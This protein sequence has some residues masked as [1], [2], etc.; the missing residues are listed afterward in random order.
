MD[1]GP[2]ICVMCAWRENCRLKY[3]MDGTTTTRCIHY[4]RDLALKAP[5]KD[6]E[7]PS[8]KDGS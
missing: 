8:E 7:E 5:S 2:T 4:T 1:D 3:S 6:K